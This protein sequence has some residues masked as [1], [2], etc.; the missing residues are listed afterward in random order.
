ADWRER[1]ESQGM[2]F[3]TLVP[4][5][6]WEESAYYLFNGRESEEIEKAAYALNQM[7]LDAVQHVIDHDRFAEFHIP[8]RF[9]PYIKQR[10][11]RD[12]L[13]IYGRLDLSFAGN[14]P[15]ALLEYNADTPTSLLEAAVVQWYWYKDVA[16][17][18]G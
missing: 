17:E 7:C 13:T 5:T 4:E 11:E 14:R 16:D 9:V 2:H 8:P 15:P 1:A 10:W 3:H 6:Y 18:L 12:E